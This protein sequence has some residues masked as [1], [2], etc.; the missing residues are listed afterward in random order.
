MERHVRCC[1]CTI[2][3][4]HIWL[5]QVQVGVNLNFS[6]DFTPTCT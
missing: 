4:K 2:M 3:G 1:H 5:H 6:L